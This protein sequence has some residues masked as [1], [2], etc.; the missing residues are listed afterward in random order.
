MKKLVLA[1]LVLLASVMVLV[2]CKMEVEPEVPPKLESIIATSDTPIIYKKGDNVDSVLVL[3][4]YDNGKSQQVLGEIISESNFTETAGVKEITVKY[5]EGGVE[6]SLTLK[7]GVIGEATYKFTETPQKL[8]NYSSSSA[9][10]T[11]SWTYV[12]FGDWPQTRKSDDVMVNT[13]IDLT[14]GGLDFSVGTDG[15]YYVK[16][17]SD[18]YKVEPIVWRVLTED[19]KV[20]GENGEPQSTEKALLLAENILTGGIKW[21]D[22]KNNYKESNIRKW[23]NG[24]SGS[25]GVS[26]YNGDAGFLQ[27]AFTE[28]AGNLIA[29]TIVDNSA[30]ST[31]DAAG[32]LSQATD[33]ACANTK[34]KIFLLSE[35]EATKLDYGF[36]EYNVYVGDH[37][38]TETSTR[39]RV[40]TDYAKATG[41]YQSSVAGYGGWWWLR[42]PYYDNEYYARYIRYDGNACYYDYVSNAD[43]GV[44]PALSI[45]L[46]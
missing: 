18:Y 14:R 12:E 30:P 10:T 45:S 39:I 15:N 32:N 8:S 20:P 41:A 42:S 22:S 5:S 21:A 19:Y 27:T 7:V 34:D 44:V 40:T 29:P 35:Q 17:D 31:S 26:D 11:G 28:T 43:K 33:Y 4:Y 1:G 16:R 13:E 25:E 38:K 37:N 9:P 23:L 46:Q 3:A 24:N 36:A 2:G 6:K